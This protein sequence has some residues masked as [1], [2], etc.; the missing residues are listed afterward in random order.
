MT[1]L[2]KAFKAVGSQRKLA[3]LLEITEGSVSLWKANG[4]PAG[5]CRAIQDLTNGVVTVHDLRPD[6]FGP[7]PSNT[8]V[9]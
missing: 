2:E 5:R 7:Q 4:V 8:N 3:D 6:I 1:S 9:A